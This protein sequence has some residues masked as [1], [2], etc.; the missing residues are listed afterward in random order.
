MVKHYQPCSLDETLEIASAFGKSLPSGAVVLFDGELGSG[1][2]TFIKGIAK[3]CKVPSS[4]VVS[5]TFSLLNIYQGSKSIFHF[6]LYRLKDHEDFIE[7]GFIDYLYPDGITC[8]EWS[9][10]IQEILPPFHYRV[11]IEH[12]QGNKRL[13]S[14]AGG[15]E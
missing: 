11:T 6:D 7:L 15:E 2:T 4:H 13:I 12:N 10:K 14:I 3:A 8:I 1:K 5:P 9:E